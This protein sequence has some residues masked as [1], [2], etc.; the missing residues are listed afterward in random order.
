[1]QTQIYKHREMKDTFEKCVDLY[2]ERHDQEII[3]PI[4]HDKVGK[5]KYGMFNLLTKALRLEVIVYYQS[6]FVFFL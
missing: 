4:D 5:Y 1:M 6:A 3:L 2:H